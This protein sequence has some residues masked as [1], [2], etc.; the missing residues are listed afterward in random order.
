VFETTPEVMR[1]CSA[2]GTFVKRIIGLPGERVQLRLV[3]GREFVYIDG[4][5]LEEPYIQPS[6]RGFGPEK[7]F[8]VPQGQYFLMGDNRSSSCDSR[9]WGGLPRERILGEV[10]MTYWPPQRISFR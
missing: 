9:Q 2:G 4:L 5:K 7:T 6:R 1:K 8:R 3:R 10:F